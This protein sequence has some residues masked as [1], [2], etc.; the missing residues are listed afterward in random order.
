M[1]RQLL[2]LTFLAASVTAALAA[3]APTQAVPD[4]D[5]YN[6]TQLVSNVPGTTPVTDLNLR[7]AWGL[8]RSATSP[9]WVGDNGT[10]KTT[11]YNGA[12]ALQSIGGVPAQGVAGAPTGVVASGIANQFQV[13]TT[14]APTTLGTSNFV[15]DG[16]SGTISA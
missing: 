16:E 9:W 7:N 12:G 2:R 13:G 11:I 1:H 5:R 15:F 6:V 8:A 4:N 3:A 10:N 14:A